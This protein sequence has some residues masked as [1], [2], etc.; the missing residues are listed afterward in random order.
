MS[1]TIFSKTTVF[2]TS[3]TARN[4]QL[5]PVDV[6]LLVFSVYKSNSHARNVASYIT[7]KFPAVSTLIVMR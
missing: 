5:S 4:R 3:E 2:I 6:L 1:P 7:E